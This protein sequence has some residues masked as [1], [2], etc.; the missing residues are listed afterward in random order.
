MRKNR[1]GP[2]QKVAGDVD[3]AGYAWDARATGDGVYEVKVVANDAG[4]NP[5]ER[6]LT[7][8]RV[9]RPFTVDLTPPRVGDFKVGR[10]GDKATVSLRVADAAGTVLRLEYCLGGD[11]ADAASWIRAFPV[12]SMADS[13]QEDYALKLDAVPTGVQ[14][15]RLRAVD[16]SGNVAYES[17]ALNAAAE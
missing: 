2:F 5:A 9:S 6:G 16:G 7:G 10:D 14:T 15:L 1:S 17:V 12:D 13:P 8:S 4:G 3:A 11:P